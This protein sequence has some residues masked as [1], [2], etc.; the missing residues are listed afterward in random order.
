M[1]DDRNVIC[2]SFGNG[3]KFLSNVKIFLD[4]LDKYSTQSFKLPVT[5][6]YVGAANKDSK[7]DYVAFKLL[8]KINKPNW[9][10]YRMTKDEIKSG[11]ILNC[12]IVFIGNGNY[13]YLLSFFK[14]YQ[15]DKELYTCYKNGTILTGYD[16]G[17]VCLFESGTIKSFNDY[18]KVNGL[19]YVPY[20]INSIGNIKNYDITEG[21]ILHFRNEVIYENSGN[22]DILS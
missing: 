17:M 18:F 8:V 22:L 15:F 14:K 10:V 1:Y 3:I 21:K 5:I 6:C 2:T 12:T 9:N 16:S 20:S 11:F 4:Y 13:N 19:G 7:I